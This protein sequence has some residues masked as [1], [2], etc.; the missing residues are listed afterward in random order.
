MAF[1]LKLLVLL[2]L[3]ES[4]FIARPSDIKVG[5]A[6]A[7]LDARFVLHSAASLWFLLI[8]GLSKRIMRAGLPQHMSNALTCVR[9]E[10]LS[11]KLIA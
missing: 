9:C 3:L 10:I 11:D 1:D 5:A 7:D 2:L 6:C 4:L 8:E